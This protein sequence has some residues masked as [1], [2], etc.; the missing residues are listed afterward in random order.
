M[1]EYVY[2]QYVCTARLYCNYY[3][4]WNSREWNA[5]VRTYVSVQRCQSMAV[6]PEIAEIVELTPHAT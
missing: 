6:E 1:I 4:I 5:F 2:T 3:S